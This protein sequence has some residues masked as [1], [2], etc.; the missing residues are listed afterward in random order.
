MFCSNGKRLAKVSSSAFSLSRC[1]LLGLLF[2]T[3]SFGGG[4]KL[5]QKSQETAVRP[6][7]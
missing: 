2:V 4:F 6:N 1:R 5:Q 3:P 7:V